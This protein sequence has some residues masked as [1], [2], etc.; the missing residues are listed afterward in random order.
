MCPSS[1]HRM[2]C[3]TGRRHKAGQVSPGLATEDH[4]AAHSVYQKREKEDKFSCFFPLGKEK[5]DPTNWPFL[6]VPYLLGE[7]LQRF[8]LPPFLLVL[9]PDSWGPWWQ[10]LCLNHL[11]V[12]STSQYLAC[13]WYW[14]VVF[15]LMHSIAWFVSQ[16]F[17]EKQ[18]Q[19]DRKRK[20]RDRGWEER[21]EGGNE[22][23][24]ERGSVTF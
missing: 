3:V 1:L 10:G 7:H 12:T 18:N 5:I 23:G 14:I 15:E 17:P 13:D 8:T 9:S 2:L 24:I 4:F 20:R 16:G 11:S 21:R 19:Q 22:R 6:G